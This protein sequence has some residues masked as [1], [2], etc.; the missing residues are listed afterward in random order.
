MRDS[1]DG[2]FGV[3]CNVVAFLEQ[4]YA[5]IEE[6]AAAGVPDFEIGRT[7]IEPVWQGDYYEWRPL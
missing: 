5:G 4:D 6:M 2:R 3:H 7:P 1:S